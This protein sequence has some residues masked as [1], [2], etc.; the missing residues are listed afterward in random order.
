MKSKIILFAVILITLN[1]CLFGQ[2]PFFHVKA[3]AIPSGREIKLEL[4]PLTNS[5][6]KD[7][8]N[9]GDTNIVQQT[10]CCVAYYGIFFAIDLIITIPE[11]IYGAVTYPFSHTG[12]E[13]EYEDE[14]NVEKVER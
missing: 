8:P 9:F 11:I 2:R 13:G 6:G 4:F 7:S 14:D 5:F 12:D 3:A 10:A 1:A